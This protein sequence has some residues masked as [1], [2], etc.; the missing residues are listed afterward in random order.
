ML[1]NLPIK[2]LMNKTHLSMKLNQFY[3]Y[4]EAGIKHTLLLTLGNIT[5]GFQFSL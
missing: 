3:S 5:A 1:Q 4:Y 2:K